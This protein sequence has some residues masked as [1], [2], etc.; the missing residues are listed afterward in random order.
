MKRV[1]RVLS[2][3]VPPTLATLAAMLFTFSIAGCEVEVDEGPLED[4]VEELE[5]TDIEVDD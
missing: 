3:A 4:G 5:E 1:T 2:F